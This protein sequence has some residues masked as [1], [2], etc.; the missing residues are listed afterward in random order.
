M[1]RSRRNSVRRAR[2][3]LGTMVEI[4]IADTEACDRAIAAA[5]AAIARVERLM[6]VHRADSELSRLNR[7]GHERAIRVDPWTYAVLAAALRLGR[8]SGGLFDCAVASVLARHGFLPRRLARAGD[9]AATQRD[10]VLLPD[11]RVRFRRPL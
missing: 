10:V 11:G 1:S 3:L 6:S 7:H 4:R 2:P 8:T 5:F 9:M